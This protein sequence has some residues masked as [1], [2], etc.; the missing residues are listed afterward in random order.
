MTNETDE[1]RIKDLGEATALKVTGFQLIRLE[2]SPRGS[3]KIFIFPRRNDAGD[4]AQEI[5]DLYRTDQLKVK[6]YTFF[7]AIKEVKARTY[8]QDLESI[9]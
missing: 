3:Y 4:T 8:S 1:V 6:A 2:Q 7:L 5:I 9:G